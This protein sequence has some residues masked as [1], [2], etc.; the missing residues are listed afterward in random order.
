M[1]KYK[2]VVADLDGTL[3]NNNVEISDRTLA[4]I[5][6]YQ[7]LGGLFTYATGRTDESARR[8]AEKAGVKIPG[9]AYN[10]GKISLPNGGGAIYETFLDA[11]R[12]ARAYA[13]LRKINKNVIAYFEGARYVSEYTK[14]IDKY[15]ARVRHSL[16]I[17]EDINAIFGG[18]RDCGKLKKLL[19]I[20]PEFERELI[21]DTVTPIFGDKCVFVMSDPDYYEFL[22]PK[23]SKGE[24]LQVLAKS[25]GVEMSSVVAMG[26]HL[27]DISMMKAA[28][29][30]VAV[31][32]AAPETLA[33]AGYV[34]A[35]NDADGAALVIERIIENSL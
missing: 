27:N 29:L 25:L 20:D 9:I 13:A 5:A 24:A 34:T 19:V 18:A 15:L 22:P 14:V 31:S 12:A 30:G 8:F 3:L 7:E 6:R 2:L 17:T 10:G 11:G 33:A 28:G 21:L 1:L 35:S 16:Y 26:D 32:N 23:T 4:A